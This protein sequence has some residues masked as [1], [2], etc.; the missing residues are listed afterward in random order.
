MLADVHGNAD[1]LR[2][3][4]SDVA[5]MAPDL[6]VVNGDVVNRGPDSVECLSLLL[7]LRPRPVF[8]QG[9]HD[10]LMHLWLTRAPA[11]P[12]AWFGDPFWAATSW[13]AQRL[14]EAGLVQEM[15][16]WPL[17]YELALQGLPKVTLAHGTPAHY[18]ESLG[19]LTPAKRLKE[20]QPDAGVLVG[21]HTHMPFAAS[22][23]RAAGSAEAALA[24]HALFLNTGAVGVP[25]NDDPRAQY[26]LLDA[27]LG[28]QPWQA[29][30]RAVPYDRTGVLRR[31]ESSGLLHSG[32]LSGRIFQLEIA[33]ARS[34]YTPFFLWATQQGRVM[35]SAA[36]AEF[37]ALFPQR[38]VSSD[39]A[40]LP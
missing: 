31:F 32:G 28:P 22:Q 8:V 23:R 1:A 34:L 6:V 35:D 4:L 11:L 15:L 21:S 40:P 24:A 27:G 25:F 33:L 30:F 17:T 18:R 16:S 39:P 36:W 37:Q 3:V 5:R 13:S 14:K 10:D 2:A 12:D 7:S 19:R 38:F 20:L 26:L 9:N 29:Q